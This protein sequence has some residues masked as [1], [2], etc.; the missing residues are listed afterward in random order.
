MLAKTLL[1]LL[2]ATFGSCATINHTPLEH[3]DSPEFLKTTSKE[4]KDPLDRLFVHLIPH[5]HDDVGWVKTVD[6]Y[7]S[8]TNTH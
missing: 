3:Q 6:E 4:V 1:L 2:G 7:Y 5:T 8:G